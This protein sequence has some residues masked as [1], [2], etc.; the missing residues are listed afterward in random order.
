MKTKFLFVAVSGL[1]EIQKWVSGSN[2]KEAQKSF[3]ASLSDEE[4]STTESIEC[5][6]ERTESLFET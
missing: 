4:R 2:L 6:D 1:K 5:I 3:W